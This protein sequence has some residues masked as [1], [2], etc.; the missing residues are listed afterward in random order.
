MVSPKGHV[1][2]YSEVHQGT[3]IKLYFPRFVSGV[4]EEE[5][6]SPEILAIICWISWWVPHVACDTKRKP[7]ARR[8]RWCLFGLALRQGAQPK[9][10]TQSASQSSVMMSG[11]SPTVAY[12]I[13]VPSILIGSILFVGA[14]WSD[15]R[16]R[17]ENSERQSSSKKKEFFCAGYAGLPAPVAL[18]RATPLFSRPSLGPQPCPCRTG[19]FTGGT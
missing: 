11:I 19:S 5:N 16:S 10:G 8:S 13:G 1:K 4:P 3:T 12:L 15:N 14:N 6:E 2:I 18:T 9:P 17:G 7:R